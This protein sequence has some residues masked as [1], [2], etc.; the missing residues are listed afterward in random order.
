MIALIRGENGWPVVE[1]YLDH[2]V[3]SAVN[4]AEIEI[5]L[6]NR[7]MTPEQ[8]DA[9]L[10]PLLIEVIPYDREHA[11]T[12]AAIHTLTRSHGLSLGDCACLALAFTRKEA[13]LTGDRDWQQAPTGVTVKLFR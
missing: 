5:V 4:L 3:M 7:G 8:I 11:R 6:R 1:A 2:A 13:A 12:T 10:T 9:A